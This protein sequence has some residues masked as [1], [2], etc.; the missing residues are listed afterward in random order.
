[1][2]IQLVFIGHEFIIERMMIEI[3]MTALSP[4]DLLIRLEEMIESGEITTDQLKD[5]LK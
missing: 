5:Y 4:E 3:N 2:Y 1:M